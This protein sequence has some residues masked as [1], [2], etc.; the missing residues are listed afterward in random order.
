MEPTRGGS[1]LM[2]DD[3]EIEELEVESFL[4]VGAR[5]Q[6]R[7]VIVEEVRNAPIVV[8]MSAYELR[9]TKIRDILRFEL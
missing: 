1:A 2:S 5:D 9:P 6:L 7:Q 8:H 3:L 4:N